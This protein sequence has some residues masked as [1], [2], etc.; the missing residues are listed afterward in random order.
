M[1]KIKKIGNPVFISIYALMVLYITN[2]IAAPVTDRVLKS[3]DII[4]DIHR[5]EVTI[6]FTFP[7]R[8]VSHFPLHKGDELRIR[9][10]PL[11]VAQVDRD[12]VFKRES[13]V[14]RQT[15]LV[16]LEEVVYEGDF[17][18]EGLFLNLS[19]GFEVA[20]GVEQ[21]ADF[22][23]IVVY[24]CEQEFSKKLKQCLDF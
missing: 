17:A 24:V 18:P 23:S 1:D 6:K 11:A 8:Y 4:D 21:G 9:I 20:F 19:F 5:S 13:I 14:P 16:P 22:R 2:I 10:R 15:E 3:V 12:A 7:V